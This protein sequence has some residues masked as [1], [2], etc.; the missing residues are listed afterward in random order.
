MNLLGS[1]RVRQSLRFNLPISTVPKPAS[2]ADQR[3][4][5]ASPRASI[6]ACE[7]RDMLA[8]TEIYGHHVLH[9]PGTF[10]IEPPSHAEMVRRRSDLV[11]KGFPYLVA[12]RDSTIVGY[13]H[14]GPYR[15]RPAYRFT[16]ENS[17]YVRPD[18]ARQGLGRCLMGT[19]LSECAT[20]DF[21]Q[22]IAVIGDS[23]NIASIRL[24]EILGFRRVGTLQSVGFKFQRW[25]D[26]VLMQREL[27]DRTASA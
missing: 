21:H 1:R 22:V 16:I 12:E 3:F 9:S 25:L 20:G 6:R 7:E 10:E 15:A 26:T 24:H 11:D 5:L 13:A 4:V 23:A 14:V 8:V 17:V 2:S 19:L 18:C 27:G